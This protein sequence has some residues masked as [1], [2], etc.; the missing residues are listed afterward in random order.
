MVAVKINNARSV[1]YCEAS[2]TLSELRV[3]SNLR[4]GVFLFKRQRGIIKRRHDL[5]LG[6]VRRSDDRYVFVFVKIQ[7]YVQV[8]FVPYI[9]IKNV[10]ASKA[11][12]LIDHYRKYQ[13]IP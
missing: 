9:H 12:Y 6:H 4:S 11:N 13:N 1:L 5:R 3:E 8:E 2:L 10:S 7:G